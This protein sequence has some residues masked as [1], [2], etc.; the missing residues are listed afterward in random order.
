[1]DL[2]AYFIIQ[3]IGRYLSLQDLIKLTQINKK[4][5]QLIR[6]IKW[7]HTVS[8]YANDINKFY[9]IFNYNFQKIHCYKLALLNRDLIYFQNKNTVILQ[10]CKL[11]SDLGL[12]FLADCQIVD[13]SYNPQLTDL[14]IQYLYKCRHLNITGCQVSESM[15]RQLKKTVKFLIYNRK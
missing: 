14:G 4:L 7:M 2:F 15:I 11:I 8:L 6:Q 9:L 5:N 10:N 12:I 13:I 3:D 1:M